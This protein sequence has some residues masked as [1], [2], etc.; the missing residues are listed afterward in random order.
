MYTRSTRARQR[1]MSTAQ[2][3]RAPRTE[4]R[5]HIPA[6]PARA[7]VYTLRRGRAGMVQRSRFT[8]LPPHFA[9]TGM[10]TVLTRHP[11]LES[12]AQARRASRRSLRR[13]ALHAHRRSS[14]RRAPAPP[15]ARRRSGAQT[16]LCNNRTPAGRQ[17]HAP[18][19]ELIT[20]VCEV[21]CAMTWRAA[22]SPPC[23]H[24]CVTSYAASAMAA[25]CHRARLRTAASTFWRRR[26]RLRL[27]WNACT[28]YKSMMHGAL[29][30]EVS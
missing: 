16:R 25:R 15:A 1:S 3:R 17:E 26:N 12:G 11:G 28:R 6:L 10:R 14:D 19:T 13:E 9:S 2:S 29:R 7:N 23:G 21:M 18:D 30:P 5:K 27:H 8:Q 22:R 24:C 20:P 4:L